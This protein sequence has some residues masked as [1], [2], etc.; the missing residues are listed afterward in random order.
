MMKDSV[1]HVKDT[2][3]WTL[4]RICEL[5]IECIKPGHYLN[6]LVAALVYGLQDSPRIVGNCCWSLMNL[7]EQLGPAIGEEK[8]TST[9]SVFFEGIITALLQFTE[10]GDNESNCRTSAYEAISTLAMYSANDCIPTVQRIVLA[11][12]DRL[13]TSMAMESQILDAD[14]RA[15]HSELQSSLLAVLTSCIRRLSR[16]I[17]QVA[18]RIMTV[19]LQLLNNQSKLATTTED[20]FLAIGAMTSSLEA[21][22][23]RYAESF[24]PILCTALQNPAE[25]QLCSIAVGLIGDICRALGKDATPYCNNL[26]QL[27]VSNLQSPVLH[28]TV[29][30]AILSCFGD[31]A[32]AIGEG[33]CGYLEVVMMVL[34]QAGSMRADRDNYD[35]IDYVNTLYEGCIEAY[36]G[37][38]QGL[39]GTAQASMLLPYLPHVFEFVHLIAIDPNR[40]DSLTRSIIGLLG[41]E[42]INRVNI[43]CID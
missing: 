24:M 34:Q 22:F 25:Y 39:N 11:V 43:V 14:D 8:G 15:E 3:A 26:M 1:V 36:V 7:A 42:I 18:D 33:F 32:L 9:L 19:V 2:V 41:Y 6:E 10:R 40:T 12:L 13:E 21:D 17:T 37:I 28:R 4:G 20:A 5:L 27:L 35:M 23:K 29:K 16:D 38:V 31:I 30:P